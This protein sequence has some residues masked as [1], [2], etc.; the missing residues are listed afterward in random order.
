M[1]KVQTFN[2]IAA[3][4]LSRLPQ[5]RYKICSDVTDPDAILLRS[6]NM[7]DISIP[8]SVLAIGRAGVGTNNIP[9]D[10]MSSRGIPVF[11][12]PGANANAVKELAIA[13]ML[14]G[15]RNLCRASEYVSALKGTGD[16]LN[17]AVEAGKKQFVGFELPGKTLGVVGLGAI[18]VEVAN[19]ALSLG[20]KVVGFDPAITVQNA[21]QLSSGVKQA[22]T[23]DQLL[24]CADFVTLHLPLIDATREIV[25]TE[26]IHL[27]KDGAVLVNFA[28]GEIV[29]NSAVTAAL[30]SGKLYSFV[31]DFPTPELINHPKVVALPHLGAST[32]EAEE[33]CAIMVTENIKDYLENGNIR[34]SVNFP[35][36]RLPRLNAWRIT[37]A[38]ANVPNMVGQVSTCIA[39]AGLNIEDLLNK[40]IGE[41]AYTIVDV[42]DEPSLMLLEKIG[43]IE[44]VL[45]LRNLGK[46][47]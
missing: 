6:H 11:N 17:K 27:M 15:A 19:A 33:N 25:N 39:N 13:G 9:V 1:F 4:G 30:D 10:E 26:S 16:E 36:A 21:W 3:E 43:S 46:P 5:D 7:H 2:N 45:T 37:L 31:T 41:F 14:I 23:L 38:N 28:R 20:M 40:S 24:H 47:V 12:S 8:T 32:A 42:N 34:C 22:D 29:D 35:E 18:G 44:G